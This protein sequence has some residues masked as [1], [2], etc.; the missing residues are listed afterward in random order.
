[1]YIHLDFE[2]VALPPV[3]PAM[4]RGSDG[5]GDGDG[6]DEFAG[7]RPLELDLNSNGN[8]FGFEPLN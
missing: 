6:A 1:M 4:F 2:F 8:T 3:D 5:G 7:S